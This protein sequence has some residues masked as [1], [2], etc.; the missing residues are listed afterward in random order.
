MNHKIKN[1]ILDFGGV[2]VDLDR[3]RCIESFKAMGADCI[4]EMLNPYYQQGLL[5][6]LEKG[7]ITTDQFHDELRQTVGKE[8]SDKQIDDAWNSFLVNVPTYKL[9][10]LLKLREHYSVFLLSNTNAIHWE[11]SC[12]RFF[13]Y[14]NLQVEDFFEKIFLSYQ[15]HQLKPSKE[16]FETV[17]A[18]TGIQP[19]DTFFIDDSE[20]N[21]ITAQSLGIHTYTPKAHEDWGHI[22]K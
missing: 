14:K 12:E 21:C 9:D 4:E 2:L 16:I 11:M 17:M 3:S 1:L 18:V 6:K 20:A 8:M 10:L 5:M 7:E 15:M 22:F 13:S 19:E